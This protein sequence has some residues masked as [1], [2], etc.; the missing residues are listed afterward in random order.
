MAPWERKPHSP[1]VKQSHVAKAARETVKFYDDFVPEADKATMQ[2]LEDKV[3]L[4]REFKDDEEV[5]F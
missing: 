1:S 4:T 5:D 2:G 3:H